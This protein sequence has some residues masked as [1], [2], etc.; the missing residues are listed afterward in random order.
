MQRRWRLVS[1]YLGLCIIRTGRPTSR[2]VVLSKVVLLA[3]QSALWPPR[4][5]AS[6]SERSALS[7][8]AV[9]VVVGAVQQ[10]LSFQFFSALRCLLMGGAS[11]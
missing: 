6:S 5:A 4:L 11:H 3:A 7:D 2:R 8:V 9:V 10:R 1:R